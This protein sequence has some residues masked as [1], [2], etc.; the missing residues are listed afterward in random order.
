MPQ[1][2]DGG[3]A[4]FWGSIC[5]SV[6]PIAS[7]LALCHTF[8]KKNIARA[9]SFGA[10]ALLFALNSELYTLDH[11]VEQG[12]GRLNKDMIQTIVLVISSMIGA[13]LFLWLDNKIHGFVHKHVHR[14]QRHDNH[15][16][17]HTPTHTESV[18]RAMTEPPFPISH[19]NGV[20]GKE[21][22]Q[23]LLAN[24]HS[25]DAEREVVKTEFP[26]HHPYHLGETPDEIVADEREERDVGL[27][28]W[29]GLALDSVPEGLVIGFLAIRNEMGAGFLLGLLLSHFPEAVSSAYL[30][31][32]DGM[33]WAVISAL[34]SS[35]CCIQALLAW[36]VVCF[37]DV[38]SKGLSD[39]QHASEGLAGGALLCM[40]GGSA[41]PEAH[42]SIGV[43]AGLILVMG[44]LSA[45]A[46]EAFFEDI[47]I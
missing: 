27:T 38:H 3:R 19:S 4:L 25:S 21:Q 37:F 46:V 45:L 44:F 33:H 31:K 5:G 24:K 43:W 34:F 16:H 28:L 18:R 30:M 15:N 41:I 23:P 13:I 20:G 14:H 7:T 2:S 6:L 40:I 47:Q 42:E 29:L 12:D 11:P 10:G 26:P 9:M 8:S 17:Q 22:Q 36:S 35:V 1:W 32:Q 39:F